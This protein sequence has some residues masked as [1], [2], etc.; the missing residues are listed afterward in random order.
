MAAP[1]PNLKLTVVFESDD[2]VAL[3][4]AKSA[5]DEAEIEYAETE[6]ALT[7]FGFS[8]ILNPACRIQVA[9]SCEDQALELLKELLTPANPELTDD[10]G[11]DELPRPS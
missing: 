7:G 4:L 10:A 6:D 1:D 11:N 2:P 3:G 8:P 9:E 5:L